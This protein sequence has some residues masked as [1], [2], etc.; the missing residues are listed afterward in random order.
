MEKFSSA[1]NTYWKNANPYVIP[2]KRADAAVLYKF[3]F[4]NGFI[5]LFFS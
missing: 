4:Y 3:C 1:L 5:F 2:T